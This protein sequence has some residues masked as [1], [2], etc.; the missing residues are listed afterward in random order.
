MVKLNFPRKLLV[1]FIQLVGF[2]VTFGI[3]IAYLVY[4]I[5]S[6]IEFNPGSRIHIN[7]AF[8]SAILMIFIMIL[9]VKLVKKLFNRKLQAMAVVDELGAFSSKPVVWNRL[10]K[11]IEFAWPVAISLLMFYIL[12]LTF[13]QYE[14]FN[15]LFKINILCITL[16]GAGGIIFLIGDIV[17]I[18]LMNKQKVDDDLK[19]ENKKNKLYLKKVKKGDKKTL[20]ALEI[21]KE[22]QKLKEEE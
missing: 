21:E 14:I 22:L 6:N 15:K 4:I 5:Y 11:T 7:A 19:S 2:I 20:R 3:P 13:I 12:K 1:F 18:H 9:Y 8:I 16:V 17:K 10:L